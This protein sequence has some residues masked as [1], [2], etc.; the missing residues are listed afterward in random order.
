MNKT[1][2]RWFLAMVLFLFTVLL[3]LS[4]AKPFST[5]RDKGISSIGSEIATLK[6]II[7]R[8]SL[9]KGDALKLCNNIQTYIIHG[10][11]DPKEILDYMN[12]ITLSV[13]NSE[14]SECA[15]SHVKKIEEYIQ[16]L[17]TASN[18]NENDWIKIFLSWPLLIIY[19]GLTL[20]YFDFNFRNLQSLFGS[21][22]SISILGNEVEFS[23]EVKMNTELLIRQYR[24]QIN[25][26]FSYQIQKE[27][28]MEKLRNIASDIQ[29]FLDES[30][31][32]KKENKYN[33]RCTIHVP[34]ILFQETLYQMFDYL[35][36]EKTGGKGRIRSSRFG[37]IGLT[38]RTEVSKILGN[39]NNDSNTLIEKW[40]M[41]K[42]ESTS[43][44][45]IKSFAAIILKDKNG[46]YS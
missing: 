38:W 36:K 2:K 5:K 23:A 19:F 44:S 8:D 20:I 28:G 24:Q 4:F 1:K 33:F 45:E 39:I 31:N 12:R 22:K 14:F 32:K 41:D 27:N 37:I 21:V 18:I 15:I 16:Q 6:E 25:E 26:L 29:D 10:S 34:D 35:P 3:Y 30:K 7:E 13:K 17:S 11:N 40:G 46:D 42:F 43:S 9:Y